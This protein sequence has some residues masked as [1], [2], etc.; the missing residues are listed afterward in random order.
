[1]REYVVDTNILLRFLLRDVEEQYQKAEKLLQDASHKKI[2]LFI[3]QIVIFEVEFALRKFYD[4]NKMDVIERLES[5]LSTGYSRVETKD[6]F[7]RS[8]RIYKNKNISFVDCFLK[9]YSELKGAKLLTFDK[10][11]Q[12]TS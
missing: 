1:M 3:P 9:A 7:L 12:T 5:L 11:I 2:K 8:L 4:F 10:K 6:I